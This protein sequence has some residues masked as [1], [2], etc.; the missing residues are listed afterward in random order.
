MTKYSENLNKTIDLTVKFRYL[1]SKTYK[2]GDYYDELNIYDI[3]IFIIIAE[4]SLKEIT[5]GVLFALHEVKTSWS[6]F[7][8]LINH[9]KKREVRIK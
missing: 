2:S 7:F 3:Y 1:F 5:R 9:L 4:D 6:A 8:I